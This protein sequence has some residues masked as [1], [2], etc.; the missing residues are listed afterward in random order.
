LL[1]NLS[2]DIWGASAAQRVK[3]R[4]LLPAWKENAMSNEPEKSDEPKKIEQLEASAKSKEALTEAALD[5]VVGGISDIQIMK[6]VDK[7]S[8]TLS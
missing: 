6:V 3:V 4:N 5:Q 1:V 2:S 8:P 7:S